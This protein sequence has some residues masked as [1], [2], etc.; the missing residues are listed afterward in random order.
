M[1]GMSYNAYFPG[2]AIA[3][4]PPLF[5][6]GVEYT[7]GTQATVQQMAWDVTNFMQWAAEPEMEQ[8]KN[9]GFKVLLFLIILSAILYA[10]KRKMWSNVDH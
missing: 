3:M 9:I 7:D 8:R 1:E 5:E 2:N 6:D 10:A 4:P